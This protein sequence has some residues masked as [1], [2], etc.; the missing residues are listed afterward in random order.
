MSI[1][2]HVESVIACIN[3]VAVCVSVRALYEN[4]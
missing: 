3:L 4:R 1:R 2:V